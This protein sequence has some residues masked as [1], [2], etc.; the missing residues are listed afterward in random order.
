MFG[1]LNL[2]AFQCDELR[3]VTHMKVSRML[4]ERIVAG[5]RG[6]TAR[7]LPYSALYGTVYAVNQIEHT[8]L[9]DFCRITERE[10]KYHIEFRYLAE[11]WPRPPRDIKSPQKLAAL[12]TEEPQDVLL[13]CDTY[14]IY[15]QAGGWRSSIE[16][17]IPLKPQKQGR[18]SL[19]H[20][21][22]ITLSRREHDDIPYSIEIRRVKNGA[23]R[24]W[25]HLTELWKGALTGEA[26]KRLLERSSRLSKSLMRK[27]REGEHGT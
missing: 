16:I 8:V 24:H 19:T 12:L 6:H 5:S 15:K 9:A 22:A 13:E 23:I 17:P 26:P 1:R 7:G 21:E 14:L 11:K 10:D 27:E 3:I 18:E 20:I 4:A 2:A 25:V